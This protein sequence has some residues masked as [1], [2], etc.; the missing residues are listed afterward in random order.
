MSFSVISSY[1]IQHPVL[2]ALLITHFLSDF[3]FQ[4][5]ALAD[6]KKLHLRALFMHLFIVA[7]PLLILALLT[8]VQNGD[9]FFQVWLS[10]LAIDY[11]KYFLN[12]HHWIKDSWE[13]GAFLVDQLLHIISIIILYH[14]IGVNVASHSLW[15]EPNYLLLQI[16]FILLISKPVNILFKLYFSKYQIAEGEE[17]QTVT[18]A[19]ALIGQ[20]ERLIMGIFLLLGQ[21][22]A[23][24]LVFTAKSIARYD[25]ISKSQAFAEYY[26]IGSLFSIISVLVLYVLL[27]L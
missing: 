15:I 1:L 20:L 11:V 4:S 14:T 8:P 12:K 27:I 22:T 13:A 7:I 23:I 5:Q 6:A 9:L 18:G 16:L 17:E 26:L 19:G 2:T 25:K 24:G 3:T 21:Y 10:H